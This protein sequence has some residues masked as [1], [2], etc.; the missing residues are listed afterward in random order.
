M[1]FRSLRQTCLCIGNLHGRSRNRGPRAVCCR[2]LFWTRQF[3]MAVLQ[4]LQPVAGGWR[5][6]NGEFTP[7]FDKLSFN[8]TYPAGPSDSNQRRCGRRGPAAGL[9]LCQSLDWR[10]RRKVAGRG[11]RGSRAAH[12]QRPNATVGAECRIRATGTVRPSGHR[13]ASAARNRLSRAGCWQSPSTE[14]PLFQRCG[15]RWRA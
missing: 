11:P 9:Q 13:P 12:G 4:P 1:L 14:V 15:V 8:P 10:C 5:M 3:R 2:L 6:A 7:T